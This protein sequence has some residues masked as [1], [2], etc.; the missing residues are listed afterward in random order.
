MKKEL[1]IIEGVFNSGEMILENGY[2]NV[3]LCNDVDVTEYGVV[4]VKI[5]ITQ[6][7]GEEESMEVLDLFT[8]DTDDKTF[9]AW[10]PINSSIS[11]RS[12][13]NFIMDEDESEKICL[14]LISLFGLRKLSKFSSKNEEKAAA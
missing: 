8:A 4:D 2:R 3:L 6:D 1:K 14:N 12:L 11:C 7:F 5:L 10:F 9:L 13:N